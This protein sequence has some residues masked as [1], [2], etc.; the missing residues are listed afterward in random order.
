[1]LA[2]AMWIGGTVHA[3]HY[4]HKEHHLGPTGLFGF[5]SPTDIRITKVQEG[6]PADG[7]IKVGDVIV[8]AGGAAFKESTRRQLAD[9]IDQAETEKAKGVLTLMLKGGKT[10]DLQLKVLGAYSKTAP[11]NC[12]KTD[13]I[14]T[15]TADYLV[16]T[17]KFGRLN[18]GL[19]GLLATGEQKYIDVVKKVL[20]QADWAKPDIKLS[21]Q[22]TSKAWYW[23]YTALL[24]CEYYLLTGDEY[25]L[26][27][28][29]AYA[30]AIAQGRD[31]AGLWG[32]RMA[33]PEVNRGKLHGRLHGY[34]VMNQSSLPLFIS[35]L[36]ADKCRVRHPEVQA[37][38]RQTH[39][40]YDSF[41]GRGTLPYG[42]HEPN[43]KS[44]NNNGMSGLAAVALSLHGN[45]RGAAFFSRMSAAAHNTMET[46]H[47]GHY[48]N[49][50]WTG[51]GANLAGPE[52]SA[53]F[54]QKTRWLHTLNRTWDGNFTYDGCG[55]SKGTFSYRGLS[56]AG[57]HLLNYCLGRRKLY[58]TGRRADPSIWLKGRQ[59]AD[60]IALPTL[61]Y[62]K[63]GD[64][65]LLAFFGH[66]MPAVRV[67][68]VWT[69]RSRQHKLMDSIRKMLKKGTGL[70]RESAIGYFGYGCSKDVA[71][72]VKDDLASI[73]RDPKETMAIRATAASSLCWLEEAAHPYFNDML[74]LV[75][76]DKPEDKLGRINEKLGRSLNILCK[77]PYA[78]G[79]VKDKDLFFKAV[80]KLLEHRR[81]N[82]RTAG[83][84]L[85]ASIPLK[86]F[87]RVA[88][89]VLYIIEDKDLTYHSYHNLGP[90]TGAIAIL[91]NL[92][93]KGGIEAAFNIL[94]AETGK[95]GFKLRMMMSVL[96]KY[97]ANAKPALAK[98]QGDPRLKGIERGR[99][100]GMW[101]AMV[102]QIEE[103]SAERDMITLEEAKKAGLKIRD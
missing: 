102:K 86:D 67:R 89:R 60:T 74:K 34:A 14:L 58:I 63:M 9:A 77:D 12:P 66:P 101:K 35:L 82:G 10:V 41:V 85:I 4:E 40:F 48:F 50:L 6:S 16:K 44:F 19:L 93:I 62:G 7:K 18:I 57:S 30:V 38:I 20:H 11:Y 88:D 90:Q 84:K 27:A 36:L 68:A 59:V 42:V 46:G 37:G 26:P 92:N 17:G 87:Y 21:L 61:D 5:T 79:L 32:H 65:Q 94:N 81:A 39:T 3:R 69:L 56:D 28:V 80:H 96:P 15:Q 52:T 95:W 103:S 47:T 64:E 43:V 22:G 78:A 45:A 1:M 2:A 8:G 49:Q 99:F 24:L 71:A 83:A 91:A 55:Y 97:G 54:F 29:K 53:A 76:A 33:D 70:Q 75:A 25:I 98:L 73:L 72:L 23:G 13:A 31:A 51:L 100:G